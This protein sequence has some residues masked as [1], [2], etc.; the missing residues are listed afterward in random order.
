MAF[1]D[2]GKAI[3]RVSELLVSR[4][5]EHIKPML[6]PGFRVTVGRPGPSNNGSAAEG[7]RLNLFLYEAM[8]EPNLRNMPLDEG[9]PTPV[10]LVLKYIMTAFD[11]EDKSDTVGAHECLGEGIRA[12]QELS[13][14]PLTDSTIDALGDNPEAL[15]ITFDEVSFDLLSKLMQGPDEKYRFSIGFEVRPVM[16]VTGEEPSYSL[17]VG[18]DYTQTP[19]EIIGDE[20]INIEVLPSLGPVITEL[21]PLKFEVNDTLTIYGN[22]LNLSGL[23]IRLG[24]VELEPVAQRPDMLQCVIDGTIADG[25][26]I[27]AGNYPVSVVQALSNGKYRASNLLV[28]SLLPILESAEF[29][30]SSEPDVYG[31]ITLA[32]TLLGGEEDDIIVALYQNSEVVRMFDDFTDYFEE[33]SDGGITSDQTQLIFSIEESDDGPVVPPGTYRIILRVNGQQ[34][35]ASPSVEIIA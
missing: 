22:D 15:R 10:W 8:F 31:E 4:L 13:I 14:L 32:G 26:V 19:R 2:T 9:Q 16:I 7:A 34:A 20:G 18:V 21:S 3:R 17:L 30:P 28:G 6:D 25:S 11:R 35:K 27:S 12:L 1:A 23:F 29:S 33:L 5:E 24:S